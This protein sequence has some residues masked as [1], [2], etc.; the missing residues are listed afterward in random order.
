MNY[1][2][3]IRLLEAMARTPEQLQAVELAVDAM[4]HVMAADNALRERGAHRL[5]L[6]E[7]R[8]MLA[9]LRA[10]PPQAPCAPPP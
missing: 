1:R 5:P 6:I 2:T 9:T 10:A 3:A 8:K 4:Q 7:L